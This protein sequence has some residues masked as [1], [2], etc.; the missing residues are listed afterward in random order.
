MTRYVGL[1]PWRGGD[2]VVAVDM[3]D[4]YHEL[5]GSYDF[6]RLEVDRDRITLRFRGREGDSTPD[7][8]LIFS[9]CRG[10]SLE[11][12]PELAGGG[13][14]FTEFH[15][16][17]VAEVGESVSTFDISLYDLQIVV[18]TAVVEARYDRSG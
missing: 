1:E 17:F 16:L 13:C 4:G 6:V 10:M 11:R 3:E 7:L 9:D 14:D 12:D 18:S 8:S 15:S 5:R 2:D